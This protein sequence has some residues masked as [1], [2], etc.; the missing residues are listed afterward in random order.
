MMA[1]PITSASL[2]AYGT[3]LTSLP[4]VTHTLFRLHRERDLSYHDIAVRVAIDTRA[5]ESAV[6][7][8]LYMLAAL[9]RGHEP[10]RMDD[11]HLSAAES[12]LGSRHAD[13][14]E[15]YLQTLLMDT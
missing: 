10:R 7:E 12:I 13:G 8:A 9:M 4:P 3:A 5:V 11:R 6:A 14:I 1:H 15:S 2:A